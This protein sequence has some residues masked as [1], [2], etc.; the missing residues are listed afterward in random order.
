MRKT[1]SLLLVAALAVIGA[2]AMAGETVATNKKSA[3][4]RADY[5]V[6][7]NGND[8]NPGTIALP[9]A[10]IEK[11]RLA[12]Q[13]RIATGMTKDITVMLR[14]GTYYISNTLAFT[15]ADSGVGGHRVVYRNYPDEVPV[16]D[17][18]VPITGWTETTS[19]SGIYQA[20]AANLNFRQLYVNNKRGIRARWPNADADHPF[21]VATNGFYQYRAPANPPA[22][23]PDPATSS[24]YRMNTVMNMSAIWI[25]A[26][27]LLTLG[28]ARADAAETRPNII[29][30]FADDWGWGFFRVT[31]PSSTRRR[32]W[33]SSRRRGPTSTN[34]PWATRCAHRAAPQS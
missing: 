29:F 25:T 31:D 2:S 33:T 17:G 26:M 23:P 1:M 22:A 15:A 16:I 9:F 12:V 28:M 24:H 14:G 4:S 7:V 27:L 11:A 34:S 32:A 10:T 18:G 3:D 20:N 30:I 8:S 19:G 6:A 13:S 5:Y 21:F